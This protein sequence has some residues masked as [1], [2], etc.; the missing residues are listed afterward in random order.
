MLC[1]GVVEK[2]DIL[3]RLAVSCEMTKELRL[4]KLYYTTAADMAYE[5]AIGNPETEYI[6]LCKS[7]P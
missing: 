7:R 2:T 1:L 6:D 3:D 5:K 4:A